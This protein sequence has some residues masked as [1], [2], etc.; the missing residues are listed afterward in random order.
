MSLSLNISLIRK[1]IRVILFLMRE[2]LAF[3]RSFASPSVKSIRRKSSDSK[4]KE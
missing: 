3:F 4:S 1:N 2:S